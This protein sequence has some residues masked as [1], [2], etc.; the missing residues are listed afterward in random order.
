MRRISEA[1]A[2]DATSGGWRTV[3]AADQDVTSAFDTALDL[4]RKI[5]WAAVN[6][7]AYGRAHLW[8]IVDDGLDPS[9]P[10]DAR[11]PHKIVAIHPLM[12]REVIP[13]EWESDPQSP[14][15]G[16]VVRWS[17]AVNRVGVFA[18]TILIHA[19]RMV[20][21]RGFDAPLTPIQGFDL[22]RG[23]S[24]PD[25]Y[26]N[27]FRDYDGAVDA[28]AV[29]ALNMSVPILRLGAH[30]EAYG[31]AD[32]EAYLA[33]L[34][35]MKLKT[36]AFGMLPM[37]ASDEIERLAVQFTGVA[38]AVTVLQERVCGIEGIPVTKLFGSAPGGLSTDNEAGRVNYGTMI[39]GLRV[40]RAEPALRQIHTV[41]MGP[42]DWA[43]QWGDIETATPRQVAEIDEINAR[44]DVALIAAGVITREEAR[45]RYEGDEV[46]PMPVV[47]P[48]DDLDDEPTEEAAREDADTYAVPEGAR[49][50]ARRVLRWREEHGDEV[51][52]MTDVGWRRA[53]Q[54]ASNA[55]VG[56]DTV[57]AMAA[58]NR[59]R[60][61]AE[62]AEEFKG[63]PWRDAGHVAWLGW[64][65]TTGIDWARKITGASD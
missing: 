9:E 24:A 46:L 52:G 58:F 22:G 31:G 10:L 34:K 13:Q 35:L 43:Y 27:A 8:L 62:V 42:G 37:A 44:R 26:W 28:V 64:G 36:S 40:D 65:G 33:T 30:A 59:H 56:Y 4:P 53:R 1:P 29:S 6:A 23:L 45:A 63:E 39:R 14:G 19:S 11:R 17:L 5:T 60:K 48:Y 55:R 32:R 57:A 51:R 7:R 3:T 21:I 20:T 54:L 18:P 12:R 16:Q 47:S 41:A 38:D 50:N 25:V 61:N 49:G 2:I 15:W